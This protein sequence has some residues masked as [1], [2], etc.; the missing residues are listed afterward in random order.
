VNNLSE[1][2]LDSAVAGIEPAIFSRKSNALTTMPPSHTTFLIY[3]TQ[4]TKTN[5]YATS[6]QV[7]GSCRIGNL[8]S[9]LARILKITIQYIPSLKPNSTSAALCR[10]SCT[11]P[12][13]L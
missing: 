3:T 7:S 13:R 4:K 8:I 9:G 2:A 10:L 12:Q 11:A 1:V 6:I 5:R